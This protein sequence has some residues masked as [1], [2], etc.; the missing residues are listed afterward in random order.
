MPKASFDAAETARSHA[1]TIKGVL[2]AGWTVKA[3]GDVVTI[4]RNEKVQG[5]ICSPV[6]PS[7]RTIAWTATIE[8]R[9]GPRIS[10]A[11]YSRMAS[12]NETARK[13]DHARHPNSSPFNYRIKLPHSLPTHLDDQSSLWISGGYLDR[14]WFE[15]KSK[16]DAQECRLVYQTIKRLFLV[17]TRF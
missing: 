3:D 15:F 12:A 2:P 4:R 9:V 6:A 14:G 1:R 11:Q 13:E 8:V 7:A 10:M 5:E 17:Y 16:D